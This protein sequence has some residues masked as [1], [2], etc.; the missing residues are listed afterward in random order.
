MSK[1]LP[2]LVALLLSTMSMKPALAINQSV[3]MKTV[4]TGAQLIS[5]CSSPGATTERWQVSMKV[6]VASG[7]E[8][9]VTFRDTEFWAKYNSRA[10]GNKLIQNDV[11][12]VDSGGFVAGTQVAPKETK[13][14]TPVVDVS[15]P[16]DTYAADMVAGLHLVGNTKQY[17]EGATFLGR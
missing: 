10:G 16:C 7:S 13:S 2:V 12:I 6:D 14:F 5:D 8:Q 17:S 15:L 11:T 4:I 1:K 9:T 3:S